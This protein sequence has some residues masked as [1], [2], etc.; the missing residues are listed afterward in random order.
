MTNSYKQDSID[1]YRDYLGQFIRNFLE[2]KHLYQSDSIDPQ[3]CLTAIMENIQPID[4]RVQESHLKDSFRKYWTPRLR[5]STG[6]LKTEDRT[7]PIGDFVFEIQPIRVVCSRCRSIEP[8]NPDDTH[9]QFQNGFQLLPKHDRTEIIQVLVLSF[10]CQR[11]KGNPEVFLVTRYNWKVTLTGRSPMEHIAVPK[12]IPESVRNY[13]SSAIVAYQSGYTLAGLFYLGS[14][15]F[16]WKLH[17]SRCC[18]LHAP[19]LTRRTLN[20]KLSDLHPEV[21]KVAES[22]AQPS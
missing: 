17:L 13:L 22:I 7:L 10:V 4:R 19:D 15:R 2:T 1:L 14:P 20:G 16:H 3:E 5:E 18:S 9:I 11:C 6:Q 12:Y 8:L 21:L